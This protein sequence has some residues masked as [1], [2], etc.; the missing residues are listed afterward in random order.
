MGAALARVASS[1]SLVVA[2]GC[3]APARPEAPPLL[4]PRA[5]VSPE[6]GPAALWEG[7][8][9]FER[10]GAFSFPRVIRDEETRQTLAE[11]STVFVDGT[12]YTY[13]RE[14]GPGEVARIALATSKDGDHF[15]RR[16]HVLVGPPETVDAYS[17]GAF[18]ENGTLHLVYEAKR[19]GSMPNVYLAESTD[20]VHFVK[21]GVLVE[22]DPQVFWESV[23][24]GTPT[25]SRYFGRWFVWYHGWSGPRH[26]LAQLFRGVAISS[27]NA[28][29][30]RESLTR[31]A[32]PALGPGAPGAW[33]DVGIGHA[34]V[35]SDGT[36]AYM[37]FEGAAVAATC[38]GKSHGVYG[39]GVARS[40]DLRSWAKLASNPI[41]RSKGGCGVAMPTW[42]Y[43]PHRRR[44]GVVYTGSHGGLHRAWLVSGAASAASR[45][46]LD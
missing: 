18:Y 3:F 8:A 26:G 6:V 17:P 35:I 9:H 23:N 45:A 34:D 16:E 2:T 25:L 31:F 37:V 28:P 1:V 12:F 40:R 22:H 19:A 32:S 46:A 4:A 20:F 21:R 5:D 14:L 27:E 24:V 42:F 10:D 29:L 36:H 33:D 39:W 30:A 13:Y 15:E 41:A 38:D 43:D 11:N 7:R 44:L